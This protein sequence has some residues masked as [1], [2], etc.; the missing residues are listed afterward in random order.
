[1]VNYDEL[2]SRESPSLT[3]NVLGKLTVLNVL[4]V[5]YTGHFRK[6]DTRAC[7]TL[8]R[9]IFGQKRVVSNIP[10]VREIC[11][12]CPNE[13]CLKRDKRIEMT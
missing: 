6:T 9:L 13:H 1:V 11:L 3:E 5:F 7:K 12:V 2:G 4:N 10:D 8:S